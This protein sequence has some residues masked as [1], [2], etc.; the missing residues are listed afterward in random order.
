MNVKN[1]L[2][3]AIAI[4][5][6]KDIARSVGLSYQSVQQWVYAGLPRT[7]YTR[8]TS[9]AKKIEAATNGKV[10]EAELLAWSISLRKEKASNNRTNNK[11]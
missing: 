7:D 2:S 4:S 9:Y 5:G 10:T 8:E 6:L 11:A 1:K 3:K